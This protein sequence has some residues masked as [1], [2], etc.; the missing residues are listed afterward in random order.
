MIQFMSEAGAW[1][2]QAGVEN[3]DAVAHGS[4]RRLT[5]I[6]L[7]DGVSECVQAGVA[8]RVSC[9]A[10][11]YLLLNRGQ[12]FFDFSK[13]ERADY[14]V[15]HLRRELQNRANEEG[16]P[17]EEYSSTFAGVLLDK[18]TNRLLVMNLGD[19]LVAGVRSGSFTILSRPD[20]SSRGC[21]TATTVGAEKAFRSGVE[22]AAGL[23]SVFICSDGAWRLLF[24]GGR[25][26]A[27]AET[28]L[29]RRA[30]GELA[31]FLRKAEPYDDCSF[32]SLTLA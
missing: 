9:D 24:E 19:C 25:L 20:D 26:K 1:H 5:G 15:A 30:Y 13:E 14:S 12:F 17:L 2:R 29:L 6:F 16:N 21:C 28:L 10:M 8:A 11:A 4:N 7:A 3:Q 18:K 31:D 27:E 23:E 22:D 32:I